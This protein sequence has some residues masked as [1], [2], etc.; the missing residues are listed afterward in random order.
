MDFQAT[1]LGW[2]DFYI[3]TGTAAAS[4]VGLLFVGLSLHLRVVISHAD[5]RALA[6]V[7]MTSLALTLLL[8][9]FMVIPPPTAPSSTGWNLVGLG[10]AGLVLIAQ[11]LVA[12]LQSGAQT[13]GFRLLLWRFG[14]TTISFC[15]VVGAG[16]VLVAGDFRLALSLLLGFVVALLVVAL[17]N[18]W[19][20]LVTVGL[21][22][23]R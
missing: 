4:L 9:L 23:T 3:L 17:R 8:A 11:N 16:A 21:A 5:V 15:G 14:L 6:R 22:T 20:L 2:H 18:S 1:L 13:L 12:G 7:T 19:D 10:A